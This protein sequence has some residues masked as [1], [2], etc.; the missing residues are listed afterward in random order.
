[1]RAHNGSAQVRIEYMAD[2]RDA[3]HNNRVDTREAARTYEDENG[4]PMMT[5]DGL[6][7]VEY[8]YDD[9]DRV[10]EERYFDPAGQPAA[11]LHWGEVKQTVYDA[12]DRVTQETYLFADGQTRM[13]TALGY[14]QITLGYDRYGNV[15]EIAYYGANGWGATDENGVA[16]IERT[17]DENGEMI[18][19]KKYDLTRTLVP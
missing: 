5:S 11:T 15:N 4:N 6:S 2:Y 13:D 1:M 17:Y 10:V 18:D 7:R 12:L 14:A 3:E 19:E 9:F 8:V 16:R